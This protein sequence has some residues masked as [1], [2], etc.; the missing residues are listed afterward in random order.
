MAWKIIV[1]CRNLCSLRLLATLHTLSLSSKSGLRLPLRTSNNAI[2]SYCC[3]D[4]QRTAFHFFVKKPDCLFGFREVMSITKG[5]IFFRWL[6][7][8][9]SINFTWPWLLHYIGPCAMYQH[10]HGCESLTMPV[11]A[12]L[13][14]QLDSQSCGKVGTGQPTCKLGTFS[15]MFLTLTEPISKKLQAS[16]K[17]TNMG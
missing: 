10:T 15:F 16:G 1:E 6:T 13:V 8:T 2:R 4:N 9:Y 14:N 17:L 7:H 11:T 5:L 3:H 12:Y